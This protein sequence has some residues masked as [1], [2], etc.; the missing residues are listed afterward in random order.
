MKLKIDLRIVVAAVAF[1]LVPAAVLGYVL[2]I[3][4]A[5][6]Y[7]FE[8]ART[9]AATAGFLVGFPAALTAVAAVFLEV[10]PMYW[11]IEVPKK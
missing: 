2:L 7:P 4:V 3:G 9:A 1:F 5:L 11:E 10:D 6:G 8:T